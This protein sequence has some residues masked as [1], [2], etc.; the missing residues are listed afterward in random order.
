MINFRVVLINKNLDIC[1]DHKKKMDSFELRFFLSM[2]K[3][4]ADQKAKITTS[5][6]NY[7]NELKEKYDTIKHTKK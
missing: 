6:F 1:R 4:S 3:K 2:E 5:Q 7:L